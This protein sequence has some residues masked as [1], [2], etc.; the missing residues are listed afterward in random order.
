MSAINAMREALLLFQLCRS[1]G[2][3]AAQPEI[4]SASATVY[5]ARV[6]DVRTFFSIT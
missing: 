3:T 2:C 6:F 4:P 5:N 1:G